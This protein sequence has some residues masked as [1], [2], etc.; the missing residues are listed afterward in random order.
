MTVWSRYRVAPTSPGREATSKLS[1]QGAPLASVIVLGYNGKAYIDDCLTSLA[2]QDMPDSDYEVLFV[3]NGSQDGSASYVRER[4]PGVRL[5]ELDR[6]FGYAEGNNIGF[7]YTRGKY[8]VFLNQDTIVHRRWLRGLVE[9]LDASPSIK[10]GHS[11]IIQSWYPEFQARE[12]ERPLEG[13]YTGDLC[14]L[15]YIRYRKLAYTD[16]P[17]DLLFL[18]GVALMIKRDVVDELGYIFDPDFFAYA[19]DLDLGL[20]IRALGY[21][22]VLVPTSVVYHKHHLKTRLTVQNFLFTVRIVRNRCLSLFKCMYLAEFLV[23]LPLTILGAPLNATQFGLRPAQRVLY[24][25][26]L[27]PVSLAALLTLP[28]HLP[29]YARKRSEVLARR[30]PDRFW[31]LR[32]MLKR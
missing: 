7:R 28:F 30:V 18:Q 22:T 8:V 12:L 13:L 3:D 16:K 9:G 32:E 21:R 25:L 29:R 15:G 4:F 11:N 5:I 31:F 1:E 19:E 6:N 2:A 20:R 27:V 14:R 26:Y 10:A 23:A 17:L 24:F